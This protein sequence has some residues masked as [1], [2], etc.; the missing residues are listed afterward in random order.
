MPR[1]LKPVA[2]I[3]FICIISYLSYLVGTYRNYKSIE[4]IFSKNLNEVEL[5]ETR[6]DEG[7]VQALTDGNKEAIFILVQ[8]RYFLRVLRLLEQR[9]GKQI[10]EHQDIVLAHIAKAQKLHKKLSYRF[11][12]EKQNKEWELL[13]SSLQAPN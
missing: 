9:E 8:H 12:T 1:Y 3:T 13:S 10:Q 6:H 7:I 5:A 2:L 4:Y 11:P